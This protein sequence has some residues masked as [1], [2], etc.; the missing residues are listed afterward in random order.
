M[1]EDEARETTKRVIEKLTGRRVTT[2]GP[3]GVQDLRRP[4]GDLVKTAA[5][6]GAAG[7]G[8]LTLGPAVIAVGGVAAA[9]LAGYGLYRHLKARR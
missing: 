2:F 9:G 3:D 8:S 7:L 5:G 4:G 6:L 1:D